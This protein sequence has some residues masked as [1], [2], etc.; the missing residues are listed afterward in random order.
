MT[1]AAARAVRIAIVGGGPIGLEAALYGRCL[2]HDVR[3]FEQGEVAR[4]VL[5]WRHVRMLSPGP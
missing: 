4:G 3:L 5:S 2:G 1:G